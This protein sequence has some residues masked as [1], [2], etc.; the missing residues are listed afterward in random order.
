MPTTQHRI[1][2]SADGIQFD[3]LKNHAHTREFLRL[4]IEQTFS[5]ESVERWVGPE[6]QTDKQ[7]DDGY[8]L[9]SINSTWF[10]AGVADSFTLTANIFPQQGRLLLKIGSVKQCSPASVIGLIQRQFEPQMVYMQS[11][12]L[13]AKIPVEVE[14]DMVH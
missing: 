11:I 7:Q 13:E 3:L 6:E 10:I 8:N 14:K 9:V 1:E 4:L 2:L 5:M 12:P